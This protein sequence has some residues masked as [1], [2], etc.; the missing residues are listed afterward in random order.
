MSFYLNAAFSLS[1]CIAAIIEWISIKKTDPA[2]FP[3]LLLLVPG[4]VNV[5]VSLA[6]VYMG[7]SNAVAF[8]VYTLVAALL[9]G[10]QFLRWGLFKK[11]QWYYILQGSFLIAWITEFAN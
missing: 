9:L 8:N 11:K 2:F 5:T 4:L 10:W 3:F 6:L 1:V 7:Y